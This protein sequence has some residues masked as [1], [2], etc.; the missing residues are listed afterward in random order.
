MNALSGDKLLGTETHSICENNAW[1]NTHVKI[2]EMGGGG[3][4]GAIFLATDGFYNSFSNDIEFKK[5]CLEYHK[6]IKKFGEECVRK[7]L[8]RWLYETSQYGSGD[9]ITLAVICFL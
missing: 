2:E 9:D 7:K 5:S 3:T 1:E 6:Y 4:K 8:K